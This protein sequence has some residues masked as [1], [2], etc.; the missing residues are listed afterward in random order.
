M[1]PRRR[2]G[3]RCVHGRSARTRATRLIAPSLC[4][5]AVLDSR[6]NL[7]PSASRGWVAAAAAAAAL[8]QSALRTRCPFRRA[9]AA[10]ALG[11]KLAL[12]ADARADA[13]HPLLLRQMMQHR[14]PAALAAL[15]A[16]ACL[17]RVA[18]TP[19]APAYNQQVLPS[20]SAA[21][22]LAKQEN[23]YSGPQLT[24]TTSRNQIVIP[25]I[26]DIGRTGGLQSINQANPGCPLTT[27][28]GA[29]GNYLGYPASALDPTA[30]FGG[31]GNTDDDI[32]GSYQAYQT[33]GILNGV[34]ANLATSST[35]CDFVLNTGDNFYQCALPPRRECSARA[36]G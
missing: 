8:A 25:V 17:G 11:W 6:G 10:V 27:G 34:C 23:F 3:P 30:N 16:G 22:G 2:R 4:A 32:A 14:K 13:L 21:A 29:T 15:L 7:P 12:S 24:Q 1:P 19:A 35:P 33:A 5:L 28:P 31:A 18:A 9:A 20:N 26:G 36:R